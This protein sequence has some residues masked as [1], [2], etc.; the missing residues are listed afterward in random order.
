MNTDYAIFGAN[1][2]QGFPVLERALSTGATVRAVSRSAQNFDALRKRLSS[3]RSANCSFHAANFADV[4]S[5]EAA[6]EGVR[7]AFLHLPIP[8]SPA[9]PARFLGNFL[10]AAHHVNLPLLVFSS[11]GYAKQKLRPS[12]LIAGNRAS[13]EAVLASKTP[14]IVVQPTIYLENLLVPLFVPRLESE[15]V[16]DYPPLRAEI[17]IPWTSQID[18]AIIVVAAL[19]RPDLAGQTFEIATAAPLSGANV[20][21]QLS[22]YLR[23]SVRYESSSSGAFAAHVAAALNNHALNFLIADMYDALN[24]ANADVLAVDTQI[25]EEVFNVKLGTVSSRLRALFQ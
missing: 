6:L 21:A 16:L 3:D 15:G 18:Q 20:A 12:P 22:K 24:E 17:A 25:L 8:S 13:C 19:E 11:S 1:G 9:E 4:Q 10:E 5:L 14:S 23:N 2:A 7:A